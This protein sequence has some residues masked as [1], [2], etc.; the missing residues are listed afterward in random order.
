MN[1][2]KAFGE[3]R[4]SHVVDICLF[5]TIKAGEVTTPQRVDDPC[6]PVFRIRIEKICESG[7]KL[8]SRVPVTL[9]SFE[10]AFDTRFIIGVEPRVRGGQ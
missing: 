2:H 10:E 9:W 7:V 3:Q 1:L 6:F 8:R 4:P 5:G